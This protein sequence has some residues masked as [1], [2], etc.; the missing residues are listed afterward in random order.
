MSLNLTDIT[1]T[2]KQLIALK[3]L[4]NLQKSYALVISS[5]TEKKMYATEFLLVS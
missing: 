3:Y 4:L 5:Y 1:I 2:I